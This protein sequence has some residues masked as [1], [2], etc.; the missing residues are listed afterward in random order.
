MYIYVTID[1]N[2][3]VI[4]YEICSTEIEIDANDVTHKLVEI[5]NTIPQDFYESF[6]EYKF[7]N[8]NLTSTSGGNKR[9]LEKDGASDYEFADAIQTDQDI[10]LDMAEAIAQL[11]WSVERS[12]TV[13]N[14]GSF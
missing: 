14:F 12:N 13:L 11:P 1:S 9:I 7:S 4:G 8:N 2:D 10:S 5:D 3:K 6:D